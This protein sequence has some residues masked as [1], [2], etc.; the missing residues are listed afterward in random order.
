MSSPGLQGGQCQ[1]R[2]H[3]M[4]SS[5]WDLHCHGLN[6]EATERLSQRPGRVPTCVCFQADG[7][8]R[9]QQLGQ[10]RPVGKKAGTWQGTAS[11]CT[12][13]AQSH[14]TCWSHPGASGPVIFAKQPHSLSSVHCAGYCERSRWLA[15]HLLSCWL[16]AI[17]SSYIEK[18]NYIYLRC[19][20]ALLI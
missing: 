16:L 5:A 18:N 4:C 14:G 11:H 12:G 19:T 10:G 20:R 3:A 1:D 13:A 15:P 8:V 17:F 2:A 6:S 9:P 7:W